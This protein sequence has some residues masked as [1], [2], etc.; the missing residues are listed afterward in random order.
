MKTI[1]CSKVSDKLLLYLENE[2]A[3]TEIN[4]IHS[5]L[6]SCT[7][8]RQE[9][10]GLEKFIAT[11]KSKKP[12]SILPENL[13]ENILL[14]IRKKSIAGKPAF[15][16]FSKLPGLRPFL[17]GA[18]ACFIL[19]AGFSLYTRKQPVSVPEKII[20]GTAENSFCVTRT[21][22][23]NKLDGAYVKNLQNMTTETKNLKV[24]LAELAKEQEEL[25]KK[26]IELENKLKEKQI[27]AENNIALNT[28]PIWKAERNELMKK[29][30]ETIDYFEKQKDKG[31]ATEQ[32]HET[33]SI[34]KIIEDHTQA[35]KE[36]DILKGEYDICHTYL[37]M[38]KMQADTVNSEYDKLIS[39]YSNK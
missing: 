4:E 29:A 27:P 2:L 30:F 36:L 7:A 28:H 1:K 5:H 26:Y 25:D 9:L 31:L 24:I 33:A 37:K 18:L 23:R 38:A 14:N 19:V 16:D 20:S 22:L 34:D 21:Q 13:S 17:A 11:V 10:A 12:E 35:Q 15:F 32:S 39:N 8:C 6:S 3:E